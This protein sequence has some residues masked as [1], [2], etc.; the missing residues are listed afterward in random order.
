MVKV[1]HRPLDR[2]KNKIRLLSIKPSIQNPHRSKLEDATDI[3]ICELEYEL[4]DVIKEDKQHREAE[5]SAAEYIFISMMC[6]L[7]ID[8]SQHIYRD[9]ETLQ[10][11]MNQRQ[12]YKP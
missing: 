10:Q 5:E 3:V 12:R 4:L 6:M 9:S 8:P 7:Y 1:H 2:G 11:Y